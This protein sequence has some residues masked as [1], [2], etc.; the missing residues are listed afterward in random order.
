MFQFLVLHGLITGGNPV[1][2]FL[3]DK[4]NQMIFYIFYGSSVC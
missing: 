4:R 1:P 3:V 2:E